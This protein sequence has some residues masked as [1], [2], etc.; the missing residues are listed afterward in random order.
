MAARAS[1]PRST[2]TSAIWTA[3]VAAPLRRLSLTIHMLSARGWDSSRR[4]RPTNT[5]SRPAARS[6][7]GHVLDDDAGRRAEQLARLL[8]RQRLARL[9]VDRLRVADPHGHAHARDRDADRLVLEDLARLEHHLALLVGVVVAVGEGARR[10]DHVERDR[11]RIDLR[12]PACPRLAARHR[13]GRRARRSPSC[14]CPTPT[15]RS[16]RPA[17]RSRPVRW[18]GAS[19]TTSCI[20]EQ[21]GLAISPWWPSSACGLTSETT[22]GISGS[23]RNA[24][25]LS[26]TVAPAC[27]EPR[28]PL[29]R[30]AGAG[31]EQ[32]EVEP[33]E[34]GVVVQRPH[35][36]PVRRARDR[37]SARW[38]T[39]RSRARG[40]RARAAARASSCR[41]RR[42]RRRPPRDIR[43]S[44]CLLPDR[45]LA[46]DLGEAQLERRVQ[47]L[48]PRSAPPRRGSRT[49]S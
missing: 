40:T 35:D 6:G 13:P 36:E 14:R 46:L 48:R 38:R 49:R 42:S 33:V 15:G 22:S 29:A 1:R 39:G 25:E 34:V 41:R 9:H 43:G 47:R 19:A 3:L 45:T 44:S 32:R 8:G 21:L 20:V 16:R 24:E 4:I 11:L 23:R 37:P 10:A 27:D 7:V 18:I 5:S 26:T 12:A 2:S 30:G 28:R 31:G 17:A